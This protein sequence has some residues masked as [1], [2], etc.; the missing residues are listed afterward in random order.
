M[1]TIITAATCVALTAFAANAHADEDAGSNQ[2][3]HF[4]HHHPDDVFGKRAKRNAD[5]DFARLAAYGECHHAV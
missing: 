4:A 2:Q 1:K 3:Q 5:A